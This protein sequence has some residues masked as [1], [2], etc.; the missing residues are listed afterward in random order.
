MKRS[1]LT[2]PAGADRE[3]ADYIICSFETLFGRPLDFEIKT[4]SSLLGGFIAEIDGCVF[5]SSVSSKLA[6]VKRLLMKN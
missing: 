5:D 2:L 3:T 4:D 6:E 1:K